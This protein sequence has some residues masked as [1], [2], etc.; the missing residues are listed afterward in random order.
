MDA[1]AIYEY[2][3]HRRTAL[4][5]Q[6]QD[7]DALMEIRIRRVVPKGLL[8]AASYTPS[9]NARVKIYVDRFAVEGVVVR[10]NEFECSIHFIRPVER[11]NP[12]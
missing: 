3:R 12:Y 11:D 4:D 7:G 5:G 9:L 8:I 1:K 10:R 6:L 2:F